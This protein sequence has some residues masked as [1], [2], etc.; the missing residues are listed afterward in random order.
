[1]D[2]SNYGSIIAKNLKRIAYN[3][4]KTQADMSRDLGISKQTIS[5]WMNGS[6]IPRMDKI[7]LLCKYFHVTRTEIME[8]QP[9]KM[10]PRLIPVYGRVAAGPP[11]T[12]VEDI[13]DYEEITEE[14][15]S[16]GSEYF[17]LTIHGSSMAP[18]MQEGDVVIVRRQPDV[19]NGELAVV[20]VNGDD[21]TCKRIRKTEDGLTLVPLNPAYEPIFFTSRQVAT[22][23]VTIIGKVVELRAKF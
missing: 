1:M 9:E 18:R 17:A 7:D 21:A 15:L 16:N 13:T 2:L 22:L 11:S 5:S 8:E 12:M 10:E 4:G 19:E 14:M 23:P 20:A 3:C 6:R